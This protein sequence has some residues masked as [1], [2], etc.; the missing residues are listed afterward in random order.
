MTRNQ[1]H[2]W[3]WGVGLV[4]G[5]TVAV[6]L[7]VLP[8][9][10]PV[11]PGNT[12]DN[13]N[14]NDNDVTPGD[15]GVT[16]K[17]VGAATCEGCHPDTHESWAATLHAGAMET[18]EAS[19][20]ASESCIGCHSVGYGE[21]GGYV[22]RATTNSL[23]GVQCENCHG[24][25]RDHAENPM[26]EASRPSVSLASEVCGVCH[27]GTHHPTFEQWEESGHA[28]VD[29]H[30]A[31]DLVEVGGFYTATCGVCHSGE[32]FYRLAV[33]GEEVAED[34]FVGTAAEDL[35]PVTCVACHDPHMRT[36]L[37]DEPDTDRDYQLRFADVVSV[38]ASTSVDD[39]QDRSRFNLCGQCHHSRGRAWDSTSRGPH[40]SVQGNMAA[41]EMP[42]PDGTD[43]L[44]PAA[45][46]VHE[47][48][49][50]QCTACHMY[51]KDFE[52]EEAP[53]I[54]GHYFSVDYDGCAACHEYPDAKVNTLQTEIQDALDDIAARLGDA[55]EWEYSAEGGPAEEDQASLS[56][57]IKQVR[58]LYHY[59]V[60]DGSLGVHNPAFVR[61]IVAQA[62]VILTS[63]GR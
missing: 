12:N 62:D 49:G 39:A 59:V 48:L 54:S 19:D 41:G 28:V 60:S 42:V 7:P 30:V 27:T 53:A 23:A 14:T 40:H 13:T 6:L 8:G 55:A 58:F 50:L 25:G 16:G 26:D 46:A 52:S 18:L 56:D 43:A 4:V 17:Y 10:S 35:L 37:A 21:E 47:G 20:H 32:V 38:T 24:P 29:E 11:P 22:D 63:I 33:A 34:E 45:T 2:N 9:C 31:V 15:S 51:R 57:E 36:G 61:A 1:L 3:G 44:V 5:V